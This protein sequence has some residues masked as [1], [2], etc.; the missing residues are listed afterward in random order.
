MLSPQTSR[1][2]CIQTPHNQ[3]FHTRP[4][5]PLHLLLKSVPQ[6]LLHLLAIP[7]VAP[8][9]KQHLMVGLSNEHGDLVPKRIQ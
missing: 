8:P 2:T 9:Q 1:G 5:P 4:P 3:A 6:Q 7:C